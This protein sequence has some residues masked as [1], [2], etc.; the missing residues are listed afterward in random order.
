MSDAQCTTEPK[1]RLS[2]YLSLRTEI[3]I[4]LE[5]LE[6]L[7]NEELL[8]GR[9]D[10]DGAQHTA[11]AGDRL[12]RAII[13][14]ME[15]EARVLPEIEQRRREMKGIEEA[16][17][18]LPDPMERLVLQLRY[19]E[20][21]SCRPIAWREISR[22]IFGGDSHSCLLATYRLHSK[23]LESMSTQGGR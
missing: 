11:P 14:R 7:K 21:E 18:S 22:R 10:D 9:R 15:Y 12:E 19:T 17:N 2:Q 13:R 6:R 3:E 8:P 1:E 16:I 20:S 4:R 23:A 5:R